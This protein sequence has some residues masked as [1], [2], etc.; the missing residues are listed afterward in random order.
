V[1][2]SIH[3]THDTKCAIYDTV[4]LG[5]YADKA[6][7]RHG[8]EINRSAIATECGF[9]RK[10]FRDNPRCAALLREADDRDRTRFLDGLA[11]A[12][13]QR[14]D[15]TKTDDDRSKLENRVLDLL[16]ENAALKRELERLRRLERLMTETGK[17]PS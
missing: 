12:E 7:P 1:R 11:R 6:L 8:T 16:A 17:L 10:V 2:I 13:L 3:N 15:K 4:R 9:D 14:D 5:A